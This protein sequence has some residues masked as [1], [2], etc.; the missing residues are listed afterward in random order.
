MNYFM[1]IMVFLVMGLALFSMVGIV[2]ANN[3]KP[4][5]LKSPAFI[6]GSTI[7]K[8]YT[9]E[10]D[11][12]SPE[13]TWENYPNGTVSLVLLCE[14]PDAPSGI[15]VHWM[16]YNIPATILA[17]PENFGK[18]MKLNT[19]EIIWP[20]MNDFRKLEYGGPCPPPGKSHR[21]IFR[22]LALD[23]LLPTKSGLSRDQVLAVAK[24]HILGEAQLMGRF[25]R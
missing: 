5:T 8:K 19:Q 18:K 7:P 13:L 12:I 20:G 3:A 15:W 22:L 11:N 14:D 1:I 24:D 9:C 25:S 17:L 6:N 2:L 4:F 23:I 10:G 16:V 21:Y